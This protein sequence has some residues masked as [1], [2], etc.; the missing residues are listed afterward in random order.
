MISSN[1][2]FLYYEDYNQAIPFFENTLELELVMDQGFARVYKVTESSFLGMVRKEHRNKANDTL[3]S[4]TVDDVQSYY[5]IFN[6]KDVHRLSK[7][8]HF[9]DIPLKSFFFEDFEGHHFEIQQ[10]L[11]KEDK[12][13]F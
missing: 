8:T 5:D 4:F 13:L 1:V 7:I 11:K 6:T 12:E 9:K 10:F 2:T 3:Y